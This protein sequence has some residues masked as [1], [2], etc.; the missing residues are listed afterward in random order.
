MLGVVYHG[1]GGVFCGIWG[2]FDCVVWA[3]AA[4]VLFLLWVMGWGLVG[5]GLFGGCLFCDQFRCICPDLGESGEM[6]VKV[7]D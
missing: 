6:E 5:W 7:L 3:G 4:W 1:F 2:F